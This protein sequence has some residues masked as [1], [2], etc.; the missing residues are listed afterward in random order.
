MRGLGYKDSGFDGAGKNVGQN[1][2][3]G[4]RKDSS[5]T[6]HHK[7]RRDNSPSRGRS[8][9]RSRSQSRSPSPPR[10]RGSEEDS[11]R[12]RKHKRSKSRE[13]SHKKRHDKR[14]SRSRSRS[15]SQNSRDKSPSDEHRRAKKK[16]K[17]K[18]S[19]RDRDRPGGGDESLRSEGGNTSA[20][21]RD[22]NYASIVTSAH[23]AVENN[24]SADN[25]YGPGDEEKKEEPQFKPDFGLS[26]ALAKDER[27]GNAVNGIVLKFTEPAEAAQPDKKWR[28]YVYKDKDVVETLHV[29]RRSCFLLG[30]D[31]RIADVP[32]RHPSCSLQ[33]AVLQYR[34]VRKGKSSSEMAVKPYIMDLSSTHGTFLNGQRIEA[35]RYYE[36]REGDLLKF[37]TSSRDYV[38]LHDHSSV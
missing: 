30:R 8:R 17:D 33:H 29:H 24:H 7:E 35:A 2:S 9:S 36:L 10:K 22:E 38:I 37:A 27:T 25:I 32:L 34:S 5:D 15:R 28:F 12:E 11:F 26:G 31:E 20:R 6:E 4:F 3:S 13:R 14:D 23:S 21:T 16:N 1:S 19:R 18:K